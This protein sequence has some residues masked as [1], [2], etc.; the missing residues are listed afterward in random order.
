M[1]V[2]SAVLVQEESK[3]VSSRKEKMP[4]VRPTG[5]SIGDEK[6]CPECKNTGRVVWVSEDKKTMGVQCRASHREAVR[7]GSKFGA[8][9]VPST[10]SKKN[11]VFLTAVN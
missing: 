11:V 10:K 7:A 9:K 5:V 3:R 8:T 4:K 6:M 2:K 1:F